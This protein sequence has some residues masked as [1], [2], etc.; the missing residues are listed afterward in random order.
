MSDLLLFTSDNKP[1][2]LEQGIAALEKEVMSLEQVPCPVIHRFGPGTY[3][4][5][6]KL[7]AG[8]LAV[9]HEQRFEHTNVFLQGRVTMLN[10]DHTTT[11]LCA[12]MIFVGK[13]GRKIGYIHEDVVWLNIYATEEQDVEKL[14]AYFLNKESDNWKTFLAA[15]QEKKQLESAAKKNDYAE[16][17]SELGVTE[18]QVRAESEQAHDLIELP[19]GGYK[20]KVNKSAIEGQGLFA[21]A[22]ILL[23]E[24]IAPA[25][26]SNRRTIAG[27]YT[28]H[29][30]E[31]NAIMIRG[32][33]NDIYLW[34]AKAIAGCHGGLDGEEITVDYR[35]AR[36]LAAQ[37]E[38]ELACQE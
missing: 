37:I 15:H 17:L 14:E 3:I 23:G 10:E 26:L 30:S 16:M 24:I 18:E 2:N 27:R 34:A 19:Y 38:G 28:N 7:P 9:G 4:R 29:S 32:S 36:K 35:A 31:P 33:D 13:P 8:A 22:D 20:V 25:R 5:E 6:V 11:E 21:T 12:P 1:L